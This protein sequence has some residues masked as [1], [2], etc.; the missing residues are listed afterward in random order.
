VVQ[1]ER[2]DCGERPRRSRGKRRIEDAVPADDVAR[3]QLGELD[4]ERGLGVGAFE[5]DATAGDDVQ[6]GVGSALHDHGLA[7]LEADDPAV[8]RE[9]GQQHTREAV[10]DGGG[11]KGRY[12]RPLP[13]DL[14]RYR[15]LSAL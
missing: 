3:P 10:E 8:L 9:P 14:A 12:H 4:R 15:R 6:P 11:G 2:L 7:R 1:A 5:A 13:P